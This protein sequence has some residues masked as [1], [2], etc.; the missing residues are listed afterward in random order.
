MGLL[1]WIMI[2]AAAGLVVRYF[3]PGRPGGFVASLILAIVGALIGGYISSY[4]EWGTL[5]MIHPRGLG[6][7]LVGALLMLLVARKLRL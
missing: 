4:F 6:L 2:G 7:A 5:T 3:L 1:S